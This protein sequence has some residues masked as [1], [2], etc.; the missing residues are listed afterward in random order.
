ML[1]LC[2]ALKGNHLFGGQLGGKASLGPLQE[3]ETVYQ[4]KMHTSLLSVNVLKNSRGTK[5]RNIYTA[6]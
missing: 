6:Q 2:P 4:E 5:S 3:C 1:G